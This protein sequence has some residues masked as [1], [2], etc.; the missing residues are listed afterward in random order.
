MEFFRLLHQPQRLA[1]SV[2]GRHTEVALYV[3]LRI[4]AL[5]LRDHRHR[6]PAEPGNATNDRLIIGE[7]SVPVELYK[8]GK[9]LTDIIAS[10]RTVIHS[11]QLDTVP[12]PGKFIIDTQGASRNTCLF[13]ALRQ[14]M[15]PLPR[16]FQPC[17]MRQR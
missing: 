9:Q 10:H 6:D 16:V 17:L 11:R 13:P 15:P 12:C 3:L 7:I 8:V 1:V 4:R 2:R 14:N 5:R